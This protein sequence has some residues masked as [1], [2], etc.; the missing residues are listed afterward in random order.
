VTIFLSKKTSSIPQKAS[1][2][3]LCGNTLCSS[4]LQPIFAAI[5]VSFFS[6]NT[7]ARAFSSGSGFTSTTSIPIAFAQA[8]RN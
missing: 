6:A 3:I 7:F 5:T 8:L 4:P 1:G 2:Y